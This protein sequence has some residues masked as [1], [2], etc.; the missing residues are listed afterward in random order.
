MVN[1]PEAGQCWAEQATQRRQDLVAAGFRAQP[2]AT[3]GYGR[4][5]SVVTTADGTVVNVALAE[6]G[7]ADDR[8]LHIHRREHPALAAALDPAFAAARRNQAGLWGACRDDDSQ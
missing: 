4:Q 1:T 7:H 2:Y 5:V 6:G 8:Y 3:D